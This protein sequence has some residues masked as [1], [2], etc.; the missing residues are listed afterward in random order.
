MA[1][2][3][4]WETFTRIPV[5]GI[6]RNFPQEKMHDT[7]AQYYKA[8]L[9][10]I[11]ITMNSANAEECIRTSVANWGDKLNI[12]AGTVCDLNDLENALAAGS[13]YIV[14][15]IV[16]EEVI[17]ECVKMNI[18]IFPGAFSPSEI[19]KAWSLGA[20][21][22]KVFP[23]TKLG[24]EFIKDVLQPL[25]K[26]KLVT[27]GGITVENFTKF[28][29]AGAKGVGVGSNLFPKEMIEEN[30]WDDLCAFLTDFVKQYDEFAKSK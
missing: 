9:T 4:N 21:M 14:T 5:I 16:N 3:F 30:R 17:K 1:N 8:G 24:P 18:P 25:N 27:T 26:V 29:A 28:L 7:L 22:V 11:E 20:S 2:T 23:A 13:Q 15:P 6:M 12:G 10:T 19:Y